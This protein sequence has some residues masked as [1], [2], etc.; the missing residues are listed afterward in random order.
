MDISFSTVLHRLTV[1]DATFDENGC[2]VLA[3]RFSVIRNV[4]NSVSY[5]IVRNAVGRLPPTSDIRGRLENVHGD[6]RAI[7]S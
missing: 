7:A 1:S 4:R 2:L 3:L 6:Y 5:F